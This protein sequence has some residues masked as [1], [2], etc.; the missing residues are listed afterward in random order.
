ML[1]L[2]A[3]GGLGD[4]A[5]GAGGGLG[6]LTA[7]GGVGDLAT[8]AGGGL[9]DLTAGAGGG[10]AAFSSSWLLCVGVESCGVISCPSSSDE[11][12]ASIASN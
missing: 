12:S 9:G 8:G 1:G 7:G 11:L 4:F 5:A 2:D 6:D 10:E 3:G